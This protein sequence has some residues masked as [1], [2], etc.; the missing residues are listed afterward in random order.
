MRSKSH[1]INRLSFCL[2][3]INVAISVHLVHQIFLCE[4]E[5]LH[6]EVMSLRMNA[7][8]SNQNCRKEPSVHLNR[9]ETTC[10]IMIRQTKREHSGN[11][12]CR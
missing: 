7:S 5:L 12:T 3:L 10:S 9:T 4:I 1:I 8:D 2:N 11:W 6:V